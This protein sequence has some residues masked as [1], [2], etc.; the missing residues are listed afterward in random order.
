MWE[1]HQTGCEIS[2]SRAHV[3]AWINGGAARIG[4]RIT[5][6]EIYHVCPQRVSAAW[7]AFLSP[8]PPPFLNEGF[9]IVR[10]SKDRKFYQ[11]FSTNGFVHSHGLRPFLFQKFGISRGGY[12]WISFKTSLRRYVFSY[13][14]F[15]FNW[16][17]LFLFEIKFLNVEIRGMVEINGVSVCKKNGRDDSFSI[18]NQSLDLSSKKRIS[19]GNN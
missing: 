10:Y 3:R 17:L 11:D 14:F 8:P 1:A 5:D 9:S 12:W 6:T 18:T 16:Y 19:R 15:I 7:W 13:I 4:T 2:F